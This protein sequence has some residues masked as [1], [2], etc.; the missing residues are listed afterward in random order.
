MAAV[1]PAAAD[2]LDLMFAVRAMRQDPASVAA[3][4][5]PV[6]LAVVVAAAVDPLAKSEIPTLHY[7]KW[8]WDAGGLH[9]RIFGLKHKSH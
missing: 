8:F 2:V 5:V 4:A 1:D 6:A 9:K 7:K 3:A